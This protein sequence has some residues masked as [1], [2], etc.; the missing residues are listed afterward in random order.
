M[1][2]RKGPGRAG[3]GALCP[4][5]VRGAQGWRTRARA[6]AAPGW[7]SG[8]PPGLLQPCRSL[9]P[10][11]PESLSP[12]G[13]AGEEA[14][15]EDEDDAEAEDPERPAGPGVARGVSGGGFGS[16]GCSG[17]GGVGAGAGVGVGSGGCSA[18][19]R[20]AVT[21]RVLLKDALLEPGVG[22]LS[23]FYLVSVCPTALARLGPRG[24]PGSGRG[25]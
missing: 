12:A 8:R 19:T 17:G 18:L 20:R 24:A 13:G 14:P 23:I 9:A 10:A 25:N 4:W 3:S 11:A 2:G 5:P 22:V 6:R 16:S 15:E 1:A 21:L 7:A